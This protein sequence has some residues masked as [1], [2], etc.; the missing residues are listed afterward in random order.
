[1]RVTIGGTTFT[2][3]LFPKDGIYLVPIKHAV[4]DAEKLAL[5][6]EVEAVLEFDQAK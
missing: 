2:T 1:M 6:M 5:G 4:R 3:S